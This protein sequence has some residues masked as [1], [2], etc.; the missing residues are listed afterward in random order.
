MD[1]EQYRDRPGFKVAAKLLKAGCIYL[2]AEGVSFFFR[3]NGN[4][5]L[6]VITHLAAPVAAGA[7]AYAATDNEELGLN[8]YVRGLA[9]LTI[10]A[11]VGYEL[12]DRIT[13]FSPRDFPGASNAFRYMRDSYRDIHCAVANNIRAINLHSDGAVGALAGFL[14]SAGDLYRRSRRTDR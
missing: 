14:S 4:P 3:K 10:A 5:N 1:V 9:K 7:Y 13:D 12:T 11:I 8:G 2:A 6:E